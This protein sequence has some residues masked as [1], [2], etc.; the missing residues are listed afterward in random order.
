MPIAARAGPGGRDRRQE[1]LDK[2]RPLARASRHSPHRANDH[3]RDVRRVVRPRAPLPRTAR[4][5]ARAPPRVSRAASR[6]VRPRRRR[7]V[8]EV[9]AID[10]SARADGRQGHPRDVPLQA[11]SERQRGRGPLHHHQLHRGRVQEDLLPRRDRAHPRPHGMAG[12]SNESGDEQKKLDV[13]SNDIF[14]ECIKDT[15]RSAIVVTEEEDVPVASEAISGDYIV[16]FDPID[17]S[18]NST[19]RSPRAPSSA[20]TPRASARSASTIPRRRRWTSAS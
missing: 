13:I 18:S 14:C 19:R 16:T 5:R 3:V 2:A 10:R 20:S 17:G 12:S 11:A 1:S 8:V 6:G 7:G 15:A 9:Q 4:V